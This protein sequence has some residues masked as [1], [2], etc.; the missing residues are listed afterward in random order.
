MR[1]TTALTT[2]IIARVASI[3]AVDSNSVIVV[4]VMIVNT[5]YFVST[6]VLI[7]Q[8]KL[9]FDTSGWTKYKALLHRTRRTS[10]RRAVLRYLFETSHHALDWVLQL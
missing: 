3:T 5:T 10:L 6:R 7:L 8:S 1:N 2:A 9:N 4:A